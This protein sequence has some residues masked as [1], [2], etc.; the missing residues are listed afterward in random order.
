MG[1]D[2]MIVE[3]G[4]ADSGMKEDGMTGD[5]M[6]GARMKASMIGGM[7]ETMKGTQGV[8]ETMD[9]LGMKGIENKGMRELT[10]LKGERRE[11]EA[12]K[13]RRSK[14]ERRNVEKGQSVDDSTGRGR[15]RIEKMES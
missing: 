14:K 11:N 13:L 3:E 9:I 10:C 8:I 4:E 5:G 1:E 7:K 2:G 12:E 6:T 15:E